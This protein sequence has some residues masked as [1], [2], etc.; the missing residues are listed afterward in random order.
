[1]SDGAAEDR[2]GAS[3][4]SR[5]AQAGREARWTAL[6][7]ALAR[8]LPGAEA[9]RLAWPKPSRGVEE[10]L[11]QSY[12][13]AAVL[14]ALCP[15]EPFLFPLIRRRLEMRHHPG[16][17][18]LPGGESE[19]GEEPASCAL[20]EAFEEIGLPADSVETLGLLTPITVPVSGYSIQPVVGWVRTPPRWRAQRE[21]VDEIL[22]A[23]PDRLLVEGPRGTVRL[24]RG[25]MRIEAPAYVVRDRAGEEANVWGATAIILAEFLAVWGSERA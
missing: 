13:P 10:D 18:S 22:F 4:E 19:A 24:E 20:R 2:P 21:E 17:I 6:K 1:M 16:Q 5:R 11:R 9:H 14:I 3:A 12:A 23:D 7:A 15:G 8:P 25:G